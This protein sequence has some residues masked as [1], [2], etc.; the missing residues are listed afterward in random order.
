M[1]DREV[2][3]RWDTASRDATR[4]LEIVGFHAAVGGAGYTALEAGRLE[5]L[6]LSPLLEVGRAVLVGRGP[7]GTAWRQTAAGAG[8]VPEAAGSDRGL[9]RIV[10]PVEARAP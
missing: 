5:R 4:I 10:I 7:P 3:E 6:D 2:N 1:K 9:W 8:A